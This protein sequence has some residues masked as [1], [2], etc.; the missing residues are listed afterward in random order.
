MVFRK[1]QSRVRCG[2][3]AQ[4]IPTLRQVAL[5]LRKTETAKPKEAIGG[6]RIFAP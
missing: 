2:D 4:N 1:G 6:K 3:S 5:N